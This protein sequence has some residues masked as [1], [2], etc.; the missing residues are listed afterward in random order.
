MP[1][2]H[3]WTGPGDEWSDG[4]ATAMART[5]GGIPGVHY[6]RRLLLM[7]GLVPGTST[8]C[9]TGSSGLTP[10]TAVPG[11]RTILHWPPSTTFASGSRWWRTFWWRG[12][13]STPS[14]GSREQ[15]FIADA[16]GD[17]RYNVASMEPSSRTQVLFS[18]V[19][20]AEGMTYQPLLNRGECFT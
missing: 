19:Y 5:L 6:R 20:N 10:R 12:P 3:D 9:S 14:A 18:V 11:C 17:A 7:S 2:G 15:V 16:Y 4:T 8:R 13:R 1:T